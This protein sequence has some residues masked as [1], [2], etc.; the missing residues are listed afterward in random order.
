MLQEI[1]E[2]QVYERIIDAWYDIECDI[3]QIRLKELRTDDMLYHRSIDLCGKYLEDITIDYDEAKKRYQKSYGTELKASKDQVMLRFHFEFCRVKRV[4]FKNMNMKT[5]LVESSKF[6][7]VV[8]ENCVMNRS[9]ITA[10]T[11]YVAKFINC[12]LSY[13]TFNRFEILDSE[14]KEC[15]LD[16]S[17]FIQT[18]IPGVKFFD[19]E[20][21]GALFEQVFSSN[22]EFVN[23]NFDRTVFNR[24]TLRST[25]DLSKNYN[26]DHIKIAHSYVSESDT[27]V[28]ITGIGSRNDTTIY[29]P[30]INQVICGCWCKEPNGYLGGTL[31]EFKERVLSAYPD[32][33]NQ[34]HKEYMKAIELLEIYNER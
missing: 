4:V 22:I 21:S 31:E 6:F 13:S 11:M 24:S 32:P 2:D 20:L 5:S 26:T 33:E 8:F 25:S 28:E 1:T 29:R 10:S 9:F 3:A 7:N 15:L 30:D 14:F 18:D 19:C 27:V 16:R 23:T 17:R 12:R 34:Y